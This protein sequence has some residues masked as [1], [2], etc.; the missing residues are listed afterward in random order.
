MGRAVSNDVVLNEV[1]SIS[2]QHALLEQDTEDKE[3]CNKW[4]I[5]DLVIHIDTS[6]CIGDSV[7]F[8]QK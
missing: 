7:N 1:P 6:S 4:T 3:D 2:R 8:R 5:M